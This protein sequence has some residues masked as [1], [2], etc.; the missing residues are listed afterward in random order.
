MGITLASTILD[1]AQSQ[2]LDKTGERFTRTELLGWL[3]DG[4][5]QIGSL[6]PIAVS[7]VTNL[8]C[9]E[10][11]RQTLPTTAWMLLDV[12]RN[13]G[14]GST[15]GRA[16]RIA[17]K[18]IMDAFDPDWHDAD[19]DSQIDHF[20]YDKQDPATFWVYPPS[21]GTTV[22]QV[23]YA[24]VPPTLAETDPITLEDNYTMALL[25]YVMW[26]AVEKQHGPGGAPS[27]L[28]SKYWDAFVAGVAARGKAETDNSPNQTLAVQPN[29]A[30]GSDQ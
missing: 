17:S 26:R 2:L 23:N 29:P 8:T 3:N 7:V 28:A 6:D 4:Q 5:R 19:P 12:Y 11:T 20:I 1:R 15:P 13:M 24:R 10:G 16:V 30:T 21:D 22:L 9:V 14:S 18:R 27:P 25:D